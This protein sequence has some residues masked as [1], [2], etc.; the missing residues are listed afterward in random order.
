MQPAWRFDMGYERVQDARCFDCLAALVGG[1]VGL[2]KEFRFSGKSFI[3]PFFHINARLRG[4][5]KFQNDDL[6]SYYPLL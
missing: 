6:Q 1:G 5:N 4:A 3:T 2:S